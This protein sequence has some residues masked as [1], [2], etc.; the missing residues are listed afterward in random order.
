M[1]EVFA[2]IIWLPVSEEAAPFSMPVDSF[3]CIR[4][5]KEIPS[6]YKNYIN[7]ESSR[8]KKW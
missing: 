7:V 8:A 5:E 2:P 4:A 1:F 6:F 3:F